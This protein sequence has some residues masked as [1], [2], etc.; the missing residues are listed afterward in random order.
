VD[1]VAALV[2]LALDDMLN[3]DD[4]D[5]DALLADLVCISWPSARALRQ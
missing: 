2:A 5:R 3:F 1:S 4:D